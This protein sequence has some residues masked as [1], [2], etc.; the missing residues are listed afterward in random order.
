M[1]FSKLHGRPRKFTI[2]KDLPVE[3][4]MEV[5]MY[6]LSIEDLPMA[7]FSGTLTTDEQLKKIT[8]LL[9]KMLRIKEEEILQFD[10]GYF[11][12]LTNAA[13]QRLNVTDEK[14]ERIKKML[15]EKKQNG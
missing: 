15:A 4:Q 12:D 2:G 10:A 8:A 5:E 14:Q 9:A 1:D 3:D 11:E 6:P 7:D 13:M